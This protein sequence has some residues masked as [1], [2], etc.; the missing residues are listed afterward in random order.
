MLRGNLDGSNRVLRLGLLASGLVIFLVQLANAGPDIGE[1]IR[2]IRLNEA[3]LSVAEAD[4]QVIVLENNREF[5]E[6]TWGYEEG[7]G[8]LRGWET[9]RRE[10]G[11]PSRFQDVFAFDGERLYTFQPEPGRM[12]GTIRTLA[13]ELD[14][15]PSPQSLL[16]YS[17]LPGVRLTLAD[18]LEKSQDV[19]LV[20]TE[21]TVAGHACYLL[22]FKAETALMNGTEEVPHFRRIEIW[23]DPARNYRPLCIKKYADPEG[24]QLKG[25]IDKIELACVEGIWVPVSGVISGYR[26][27]PV[28]LDGYT[29]DEL[30]AMEPGE[31]V[32]HL[33]FE[34]RPSEI[35][36][37]R[38]QIKAWRILDDIDDALFRVEFPHGALVWDA[39]L[40]RGYRVGEEEARLVRDVS[41]ELEALDKPGGNQD[42]WGQPP[43]QEA[44]NPKPQLAGPKPVSIPWLTYA[45]ALTL[46]FLGIVLWFG[47][48][49]R[50]RGSRE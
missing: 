35:T 33:R 14:S 29:L 18:V 30:R 47:L 50:R 24:A 45:V 41:S 27:I 36:P 22:A 8:Y 6:G 2:S 26:T 32:K 4:F 10:D 11:T 43:Q 34:S 37:K 25:V 23:I 7:K 39:F 1:V 16:G 40:Q 38:I 46:C 15:F 49:R 20:S 48:C 13:W 42:E 31:A 5:Y 17:Y 3:L 28:P 21:E 12:S 19:E 9:L 44:P